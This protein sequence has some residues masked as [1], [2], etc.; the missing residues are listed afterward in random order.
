MLARGALGNPW[1][2]STLL[3]LRE[4]APPS[5]SEVADEFEWVLDRTVEHLDERAGRYLRKHYPWYVERLAE[6]GV[7]TPAAGGRVLP[8]KR[9]QEALQQTDDVEVARG[10]VRAAVAAPVAA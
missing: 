10:L 2:F 6:A 8:D 3:G 7:G 5:A 9:L 4:D 1:L